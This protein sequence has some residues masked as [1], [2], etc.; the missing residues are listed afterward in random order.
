MKYRGELINSDFSFCAFTTPS[1]ENFLLS[2]EQSD[3]PALLVI[4]DD[5]EVSPKG[6][7]FLS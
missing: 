1:G 7:K 6:S 5:K 4:N 2:P 3:V